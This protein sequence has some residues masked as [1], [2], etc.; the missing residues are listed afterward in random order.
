MTQ[1]SVLRQL[2]EAGKLRLQDFDDA[3][4]VRLLREELVTVDGQTVTLSDKG[5][6]AVAPKKQE[7]RASTP[8]HPLAP[9]RRTYPLGRREQPSKRGYYI[10][11]ERS[12]QQAAAWLKRNPPP[13]FDWSNPDPENQERLKRLRRILSAP[14]RHDDGT[15]WTVDDHFVT[16]SVAIWSSP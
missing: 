10:A 1:R 15:E 5:R 3:A 11:E 7:T 12:R 14:L 4:L 9:M 16:A 2:A 8:A 13:P 6:R